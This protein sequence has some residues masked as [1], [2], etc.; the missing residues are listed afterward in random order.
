MARQIQQSLASFENVNLLLFAA[1]EHGARHIALRSEG[2][3]TLLRF[4]GP[5]GSE[6]MEPLSLPY[7]ETVRRLREMKERFGR[8]HVNMGGQE[9]HLDVV[10]SPHRWPDGVFLHMRSV[11]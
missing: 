7:Q 6:H 11:D 4:L 9:W 2:D 10:V 8:V 5:D 1:W 3:C